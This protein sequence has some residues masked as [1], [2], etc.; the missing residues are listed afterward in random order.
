MSDS[1]FWDDLEIDYSKAMTE[2]AAF[3]KAVHEK[4]EELKDILKSN[5]SVANYLANLPKEDYDYTEV[6]KMIN[7]FWYW[8][9]DNVPTQHLKEVASRL[10]KT[11]GQIDWMEK[12]RAQAEIVKEVGDLDKPLANLQYIKLRKGFQRWIDAMNLLEMFDACGIEP[13]EALKPLPGN[14]GSPV[15]LSVPYMFVFGNETAQYNNPRAVCKRLGIEPLN[16]ADL[17]DWIDANPDC[18][19]KYGKV[20]N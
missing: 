8:V 19:I 2:P 16:V 7:A 14:Y 12:D 20:K 18:D 1:N 6:D 13:P 3:A 11:A 9:D 10:R 17:I 15:G 4:G 5:N